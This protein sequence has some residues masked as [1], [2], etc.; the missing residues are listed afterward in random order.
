MW[1]ILT[2][3]FFILIYSFYEYQNIQ[4]TKITGE[5]FNIEEQFGL[6]II[7]IADIQYDYLG[8]F[9][10]KKLMIKVVDLINQQQPDLVIFGGD[11]IHHKGNQVFEYLKNINTMKI[12]ILGNHDYFDL[13]S[14]IE[15]C[16][17]ANIKLLINESITIHEITFI[18][19]DN[20][21][22][23]TPQL[24][25]INENNFNV[26]LV[27][28]PDDFEQLSQNYQFDMALAGH[29]HGGQVTLFG[30]YA[31]I[32]PSAYKQKYRHGLIKN[33]T[34]T[35]YV[36][37]G[38]GGFVFGLPIRFFAKPEI[39]LIDLTKKPLNEKGL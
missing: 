29:L 16:K 37:S 6:K 19:L 17:H 12:G 13:E 10:N 1:I 35:I 34:N 3:G 25:R 38:L 28:D 2:I 30:K 11:Y 15:G 8:I 9:F 18:G 23:G 26:L 4:I 21:R 27:H 20:S 7:Y 24:P 5:D 14:V 22:M 39:V 32:L 31:P 33:N 36:T